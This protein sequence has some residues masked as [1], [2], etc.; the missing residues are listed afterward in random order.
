MHAQLKTILFTYLAKYEFT[1]NH[2][3]HLVEYT[4]V[5]MIRNIKIKSQNEINEVYWILQTFTQGYVIFFHFPWKAK[6]TLSDGSLKG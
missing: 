4:R 1:R 5:T 3:R 6:N 2:Q